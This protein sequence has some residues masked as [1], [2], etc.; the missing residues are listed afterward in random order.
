MLRAVTDGIFFFPL[1]LFG[2]KVNGFLKG[3]VDRAAELAQLVP[4]SWLLLKSQSRAARSGIEAK[5]PFLPP[6]FQKGLKPAVDICITAGEMGKQQ[7]SHPITRK[8]SRVSVFLCKGLISSGPH[9]IAAYKCSMSAQLLGHHAA[10]AER[11][12]PKPDDG[13]VLLLNSFVLAGLKVLIEYYVHRCLHSLH[14]S[15]EGS[16]VVIWAVDWGRFGD[17]TPHSVSAAQCVEH[18]TEQNV[19]LPGLSDIHQPE[20]QKADRKQCKH[21]LCALLEGEKKYHVHFKVLMRLIAEGARTDASK[22]N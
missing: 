21:V 20:P 3:S 5:G 4:S 11:P 13:T 12:V 6:A 7:S 14:F 22:R 17:T 16:Q 8:Q 9:S 1:S 15:P 18:S 10:P 2:D 19:V